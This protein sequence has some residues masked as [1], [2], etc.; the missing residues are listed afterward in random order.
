MD[1]PMLNEDQEEAWSLTRPALVPCMFAH[2]I[3]TTRYDPLYSKKLGGKSHRF[4]IGGLIDRE[5]T[6]TGRP[7][8]GHSPIIR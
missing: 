7:G 4:T 2:N 1:L 3:P 8:V 5:G 6:E